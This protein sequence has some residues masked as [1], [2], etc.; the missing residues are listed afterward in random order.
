MLKVLFGST[1]GIMS[2]VTI[3]LTIVVISGWLLYFYIKQSK[4]E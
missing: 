1:V 4:S 3:S 2:V